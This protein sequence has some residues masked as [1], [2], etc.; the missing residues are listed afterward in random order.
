[1]RIDTD[2][3]VKCDDG[4]IAE[5]SC[6]SAEELLHIMELESVPDCKVTTNWMGQ[7]VITKRMTIEDVREWVHLNQE[8]L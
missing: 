5:V 6:R 8:L 1:M 7:E 3:K 4:N 2:I